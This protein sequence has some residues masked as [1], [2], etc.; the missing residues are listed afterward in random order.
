MSSGGGFNLLHAAHGQGVHV[1]IKPI[2]ICFAAANFAFLT[3]APLQTLKN[4]EF[5]ALSSP[6]WLPILLGRFAVLRWITANRLAFMAKQEYV[7]LEIRLPR[8]VRKTPLA[9]EAVLSSMHLSPG[10][11]TW[12]KR[13]VN[14][15]VRPS[16]SLEIASL[17]GR[18]HMYV[19]TRVGFRRGIESYFYA[20]YP[21]VELVEATDYTL[22]I[23][24]SHPPYQT[25][26]CEYEFKNSDVYPFRTYAEFMKPDAPLAKPEEQVDPLA[27]ILEFLGSLGP[28]E[29]FWIQIN[30]RVTKDEKFKN[31][32][33]PDGTP[34]TLKDIKKDE[35]ESI[36]RSTIQELTHYD[37]V[38]GSSYKTETFPNPTKGQQ[39]AMETIER[40][41]SKPLF[42]VGIRALYT[43]PEDAFQGTVISH[44]IGVWKPF[45]SETGNSFGVTRWSAIFDGWPWE[46]P[47]G[48]HEA[49][50]VHQLVDAYRRRSY[51]NEPYIMPWM[52]MNTEELATLFHIPAAGVTTPSLPRIQSSTSEAPSNLPTEYVCAGSY[53]WCASCA[54]DASGAPL[55][56]LCLRRPWSRRA[57]CVRIRTVCTRRRLCYPRYHRPPCGSGY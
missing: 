29:Q 49:H 52:I 17:G 33:K 27:Q 7:L 8:D 22:L 12:Y 4:Y 57:W 10:E 21:G 38:S 41:L 6:L 13:L 46:D 34:Y 36:R 30:I 14:G 1:S 26:G 54:R 11:S 15:A 9:M 48:Q 18:V 53:A 50:L 16:F 43:A 5:L 19:R 3:I 32:K 24:P 20:Q 25:W 28:K 55:V 31:H 2:A 35:L 45:A 51:F 42:D 56:C 47:G 37:P 39:L 23:D 40:K 44:L